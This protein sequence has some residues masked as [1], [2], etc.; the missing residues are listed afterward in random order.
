MNNSGQS[1]VQAAKFYKI[2]P[3]RIV[4]FHDE[5]DIVFG[6]IKVK[7]GGGHAGHNGLKSLDSHLNSQDYWRV[8]IGIGHPGDKEKVHGHVLSDFSKAERQSVE[9]MMQSISRHVGLLLDGKDTDFMSKVAM[10][11]APQA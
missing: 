4:V 2:D 3:E 10:E 9:P 5:L 8:R 11:Y 6:K 1:V 7:K